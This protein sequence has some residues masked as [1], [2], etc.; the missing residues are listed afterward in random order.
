MHSAV[1]ATAALGVSPLVRIR[2]THPDLIKRALD[3][4]AQCV[5]W[6]STMNQCNAD[7]YH[8]GIVVPQVSTAAE[9]RDV[10]S[11]ST[12]PPHGFR[13]QGSAF[14]GIA[15]GVDIATYMKTANETIITCVQIETREG[16]ENVD[17]ICAVH[18]I[19]KSTSRM[20]GIC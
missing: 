18:G 1:A 10:V 16:V 2:M 19:G 6:S 9:A 5:S 20:E 17:A 11:A 13:G 3:A 14:P 12:F 8:S 4:G 7:V 15:H